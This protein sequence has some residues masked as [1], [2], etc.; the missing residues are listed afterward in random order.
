LTSRRPP[1]LGSFFSL[2]FRQLRSSERVIREHRRSRHPP[3]AGL[4]DKRPELSLRLLASFWCNDFQDFSEIR[5][6]NPPH[7]PLDLLTDRQML[8][9]LCRHRR[10][11]RRAF[12]LSRVE[13]G[14][15]LPPLFL[16]V[17]LLGLSPCCLESECSG[18]VFSFSRKFLVRRF[19][20]P[21]SRLCECLGDEACFLFPLSRPT[22]FLD[23]AMRRLRRRNQE[24]VFS[25]P[26]WPFFSASIRA[27]RVFGVARLDQRIDFVLTFGPGVGLP[28]IGRPQRH[29]CQRFF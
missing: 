25:D 6:R 26:F 22:P 14:F 16:M 27:R 18:F 11:S 19:K 7:F 17:P 15:D 1:P 9:V 5:N 20:A 2:A 28:N 29:F 23:I 4:S 3:P 24:F 8:N 21:H 10:S 13:L 12:A